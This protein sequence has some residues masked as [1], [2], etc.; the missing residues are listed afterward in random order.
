MGWLY[1]MLNCHILSLLSFTKLRDFC[2]NFEFFSS[3]RCIQSKNFRSECW[4]R[5]RWNLNIMILRYNYSHSSFH[6]CPTV[7]GQRVLTV[8]TKVKSRFPHR[9]FTRWCPSV[10]TFWKQNQWCVRL[11]TH[12]SSESLSSC[13]SRKIDPTHRYGMP[14]L[15][16]RL[17]Q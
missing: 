14:C 4:T 9:K 10:A 17:R 12:D 7:F 6:Y 8:N 3:T 2:R 15:L 11:T 1:L 16:W 13:V 5:P